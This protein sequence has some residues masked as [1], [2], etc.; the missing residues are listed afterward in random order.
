MDGVIGPLK[1]ADSNVVEDPADIA[2]LMKSHYEADCVD[3]GEPQRLQSKR[4]LAA[5]HRCLRRS[6]GLPPRRF[7][8][9]AQPPGLRCRCS[10][11]LRRSSRSRSSS[12]GQRRSP[13]ASPSGNRAIRP[14]YIRTLNNSSLV[15]TS[16]VLSSSKILSS[17][18]LS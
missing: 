14:Q 10:K 13:E 6:D 3:P 16:S 7:E 8:L 17:L 18:I 9:P 2:E 4:C 15:I 12:R 1:D 5:T 11:L